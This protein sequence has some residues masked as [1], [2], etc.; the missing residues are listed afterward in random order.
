MEITPSASKPAA[1][2]P[3]I[4]APAA[5]T[6]KFFSV[7]WCAAS[8]KKH[9][10]MD[11]GFLNI[12]PPDGLCTLRDSTGKEVSKTKTKKAL[13]DPSSVTRV[14]MY[15]VQVRTQKEVWKA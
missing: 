5:N 3:S 14:G 9:K 12:A 7:F 2:T 13:E 4:P 1:S 10:A 11:T 15:E 6:T 8:T